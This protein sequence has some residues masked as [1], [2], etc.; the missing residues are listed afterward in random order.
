VFN[1]RFNSMKSVTKGYFKVDSDFVSYQTLFS[2]LL[3]LLL[4]LLSST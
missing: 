2:V 1:E 3:A 4:I